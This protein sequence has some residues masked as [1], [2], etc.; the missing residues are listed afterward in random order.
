[1]L[2][3]TL[4]PLPRMTHTVSL[5]LANFIHF[6]R[7]TLEVFNNCCVGGKCSP[8][9][10]RRTFLRSS[11]VSSL[12]YPIWLPPAAPIAAWPANLSEIQNLRAHPRPTESESEFQ[13][14]RHVICMHIKVEKHW[15]RKW[16]LSV[17]N[18]STIWSDFNNLWIRAFKLIYPAD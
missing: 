1:M 3:L 13:Q 11:R 2:F 7:S 18:F 8:V 5:Q 4:F 9:G 10:H 6:S 12:N 15:A 14:D 16:E 17:G